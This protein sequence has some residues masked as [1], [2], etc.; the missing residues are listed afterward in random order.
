MSR[1]HTLTIEKIIPGGNGLAR[2]PDGLVVMVPLVLPGEKVVVEFFQ[3]KRGF[4]QANLVEVLEAS[5]LRIEAPCPCYGQC[6]GCDLQHISYQGQLEIKQQVEQDQ[7]VRSL[8]E[9]SSGHQTILAIQRA[10]EPFYYRQRVRFQVDG[11]GR[12]GFYRH[13]S[14]EV[15]P[16]L[17]CLL[18]APKI[19]K[20]LSALLASKAAENLLKNSEA[21]EL[22]HD[23]RE[24]KVIAFFH[25]IRKPRA[26]DISSAKDCAKNIQE[27][28]SLLLKTKSWGNTGPFLGDD[29]VEMDQ[30]SLTLLHFSVPLT[31][32][33]RV[34]MLFE[35][36]GF[37]QVN[38]KQ[39]ET[40]IRT[41]LDW[42]NISRETTILDL[43]CGLGNFSIPA[44]FY[45]KLVLGM[46]LQRSAIRSA[47]QN[48][49][50]NGLKNVVFEQESALVAARKLAESGTSFDLVI[51]DPPRQGCKEIIPFLEK[52]ALAQIIYISCDPATLA[53][54]L[55]LLQ[56]FGF[57]I[58][59]IQ[60][61]DMFPQT[62]HIETIVQLTREPG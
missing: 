19:N 8:G 5:P 17:Q 40:M 51:L 6:G 38:A 42:A 60:G 34:D 31:D 29:S 48:A 23:Q 15:V 13:R 24:D 56:N 39:N 43:Y 55:L 61:V 3:E 1:Y 41:M 28:K 36:G 7:L 4:V 46:D 58:G 45:G 49:Q 52:I 44:A 27:I 2:R 54:D 47:Q 50:N 33:K 9:N 57:R 18:A 22:M 30:R 62:H 53:R 20:V 14:K 11:R 25:Y 32:G 37:C 16:I 21:V 26:M 59:K 12:M 35:A 10:Q